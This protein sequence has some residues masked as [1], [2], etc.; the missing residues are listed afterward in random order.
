[1]TLDQPITIVSDRG[2][3]P[4]IEAGIGRAWSPAR[5]KTTKPP[6]NTTASTGNEQAAR[7]GPERSGR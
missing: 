5:P 2:D 3:H 6:A 1:M 4:A 7:H